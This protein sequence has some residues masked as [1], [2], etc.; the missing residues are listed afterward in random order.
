MEPGR[1]RDPAEKNPFWKPAIATFVLA[2]ALW[3]GERSQNFPVF[4]VLGGLGFICALF[5]AA[6]SV[7][8][9]D[10]YRHFMERIQD[11][12]QQAADRVGRGV[13]GALGGAATLAERHRAIVAATAALVLFAV[14]GVVVWLS[15]PG[16]AETG[17][18]HSG[19]LRLLTTPAGLASYQELARRYE[20]YTADQNRDHPHCPTE[21]LYVYD[22]RPDLVGA[23]LIHRW[24]P[25]G[26]LVPD[27]VL[28]PQPDAWLPESTV[29]VRA[30]QD[31]A[32]RSRL[33]DPV[34]ASRS[35]GSS[36]L[37]LASWAPI[38]GLPASAATWPQAVG[39]VIGS[40]ARLLAPDPQ[41]STAGLF[42]MS[43]YLRGASGPVE[44]NEARRREQLIDRSG[45]VLRDDDVATLCRFAGADGPGNRAVITSRQTWQRY[46]DGQ[47]LGEACLV[48][49]GQGG[50]F[51]ALADSPVLDHPL[52]DLDWTSDTRRA[53]LGAFLNWLASSAGDDAREAIGLDLPRP[54]CTVLL[55]PDRQGR[56]S[57]GSEESPLSVADPCMP[58][59][60]EDVLRRYREAQRPGA[61]LLS[62]DASGSMG[63]TVGR[64]GPTRLAVAIQAVDRALDQLG[65]RDAVGVWTFAGQGHT[66]QVPIAPG[67]E[68]QRSLVGLKLKQVRPGGTTPMYDTVF[69]GLAEVGRYGG[70]DAVEPFRA[71][72]VLTDGQDSGQMPVKDAADRIAQLTLG[73]AAPRLFIVA[74]G[75]ASC[76]G[77]NGLH[78]L[79][80]A[81]RGTCYDAAL[82]QVGQTMA[83]LFE[84]LW[85]G[86]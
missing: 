12:L 45:A 35:I 23:A 74:T 65:P 34:R 61:V 55:N 48:G 68:P 5:A 75:E 8:G 14:G 40:G 33:R 77:A 2:L 86:E 38:D 51:V 25:N 83:A 81:G 30:V 6:V 54:D 29:D 44:L 19:E 58:G 79:T 82:S 7:A 85:K 72:V 62:V 13:R 78:V 67:D 36:A 26:D 9:R 56:D 52:V 76:A 3:Y 20:R 15:T 24:S 11:G 18:P 71:L 57:K 49:A 27:V 70:G 41:A 60:L 84:S 63:A 17:C 42:A 22:A 32:G 73:P 53:A 39:A 31:L 1:K 80:D 66:G 64:G 46:V 10:R 59:G 47:Y 4:S 28:G 69:A 43:T 16:E 37:V 50:H 21:H